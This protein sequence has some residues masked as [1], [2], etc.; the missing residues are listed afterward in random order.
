MINIRPKGKKEI[1]Q[2]GGKYPRSPKTLILSERLDS[3]TNGVIRA[4]LTICKVLPV[5]ANVGS[6]DVIGSRASRRGRLE[7][8]APEVGGVEDIAVDWK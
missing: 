7:P 5:P 2:E 4:S 8:P 3:V 1:I 6:L